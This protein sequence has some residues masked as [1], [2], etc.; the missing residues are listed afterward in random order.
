[1]IVGD[2]IKWEKYG[3]CVEEVVKITQ[4]NDDEFIYWLRGEGEDFRTY[5]RENAF[6]ILLENDIVTVIRNDDR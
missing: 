6:K 3:P 4:T 2:K 5:L 1:M